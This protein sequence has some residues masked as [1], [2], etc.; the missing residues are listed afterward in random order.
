MEPA[1]DWIRP[2]TNTMNDIHKSGGKLPGN[3]TAIF[4]YKPCE[5]PNPIN[6]HRTKGRYTM[7]GNKRKYF[8]IR[9]IA[10]KVSDASFFDSFCK[11]YFIT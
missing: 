7:N 8:L 3:G 1:V 10:K 11:I 9:Y 4:C 2:E 6:V 5:P